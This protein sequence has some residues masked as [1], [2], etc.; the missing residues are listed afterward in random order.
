MHRTTHPNNNVSVATSNNALILLGNFFNPIGFGRAHF[1]AALYPLSHHL[2]FGWALLLVFTLQEGHVIVAAFGEQGI[3]RDLI[4][5]LRVQ[6]GVVDTDIHN[7]LRMFA[8]GLIFKPSSVRLN[9]KSAFF[10]L[11]LHVF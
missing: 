1:T 7:P 8:L 9:G 10:R 11:Q 4:G 2:I 5:A 3:G 6:L